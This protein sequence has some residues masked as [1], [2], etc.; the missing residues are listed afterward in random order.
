MPIS[1]ARLTA[2]KGQQWQAR[3][4]GKC[5]RCLCLRPVE[6]VVSTLTVEATGRSVK[7]V[8]REVQRKN[9]IFISI[10]FSLLFPHWF[11][12]QHENIWNIPF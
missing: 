8:V 5:M 4:T 7:V 12:L 3:S 1:T 10:Y 9:I 2:L 11:S 6:A